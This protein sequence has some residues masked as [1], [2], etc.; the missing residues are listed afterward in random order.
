MR[1]EIESPQMARTVGNLRSTPKY[2]PVKFHNTRDKGLLR[3][4]ERHRQEMFY[5]NDQD[6]DFSTLTLEA[7][8]PLKKCL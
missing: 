8:R 2:I 7:K 4:R 1:L 3:E 5:I 6:S